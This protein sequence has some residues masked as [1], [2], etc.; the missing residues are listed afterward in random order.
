M[1]FSDARLAELTGMDEAAVSA[2]RRSLKVRPVFKRVDTCAA[3]FESHTPYMYSTY[4][5]G[6]GAECEAQPEDRTK[7]I[8]LGGG[9]NRLGQGIEFYYS[10]AHAAFA[11]KD[12]GVKTIQ[13]IVRASWQER[14]S[15]N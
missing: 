10:C 13:R 8:I 9:P 2:H 4:E 3:E 11:L 14:R 15:K 5:F 6:P 7:V 1:G 12:T